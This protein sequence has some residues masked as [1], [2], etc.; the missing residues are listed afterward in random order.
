MD[1]S[2]NVNGCSVCQPDERTTQVLWPKLAG[3]RSKDGNTIIARRA[4]NSSP[5]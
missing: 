5:A 4:A 2:I 3:K 1:N